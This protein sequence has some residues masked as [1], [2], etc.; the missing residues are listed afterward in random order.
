VLVS[1]DAGKFII[2]NPPRKV[3]SRYVR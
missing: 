2:E 3:K 1:F